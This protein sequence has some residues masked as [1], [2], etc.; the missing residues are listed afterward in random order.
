MQREIKGGINE[1]SSHLLLEKAYVYPLSKLCPDMT[2]YRFDDTNGYWVI[3][4]TG[5][6]FVLDPMAQ[7]PRSKKCD[8]ETGED[9]KGE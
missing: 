9:Q 2:G 7:G 1:M 3:E 8:V 6:P 4:K 5:K